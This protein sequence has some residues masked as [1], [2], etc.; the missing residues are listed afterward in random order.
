MNEEKQ[1]KLLKNQ[2]KKAQT[3]SEYVIAQKRGRYETRSLFR[4]IAYTVPLYTFIKPVFWR[5]YRKLSKVKQ[6]LPFRKLIPTADNSYQYDDAKCNGCG[7]C[8]K[9]CPVNNIKII[10][11][12]PQWQNH[13]ETCYACFLWCPNEAI[14]GDIVSYND[15]R[16]HP[17]VNL[18]DILKENSQAN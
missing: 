2:K 13:C 5:R 15:R 12:R 10:K 1:Q 18:T 8:S 17:D 11:E 6:F 7:V 16:H 4:K 3:I 14:Y 9:V